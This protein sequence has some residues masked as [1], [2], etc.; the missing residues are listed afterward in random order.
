MD[1]EMYD[2]CEV[3]PSKKKK[4]SKKRKHE[5][6]VRY[7]QPNGEE[8]QSE[9]QSDYQQNEDQNGEH[10]FEKPK[11]KSKKKSKSSK[12][13]REESQR[14]SAEKSYEEPANEKSYEEPAEESDDL[15]QAESIQLDETD[16]L[17]EE[18]SYDFFGQQE[19]EEKP[20]EEKPVEEEATSR[21]TTQKSY[22]C[23]PFSCV[24]MMHRRLK[25]PLLPTAIGHELQV[26][27][28]TLVHKWKYNFINELNG[29]LYYFQNVKLVQ[30]TY[31]RIMDDLPYIYC[32]ITADFY[33][34][35]PKVGEY[36]KATISW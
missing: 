24:E 23:E 3:T 10:S 26:I 33:V 34:F 1:E 22:H 18:A 30:G 36:L 7:E 12:R 9:E 5:E 29:F 13:D 20:V 8:Q 19:E 16:R 15:F 6:S 14:R 11:S 32:D 27:T 21:A 2:E 28:S 25:F 4:K 31:G 17:D 35:K